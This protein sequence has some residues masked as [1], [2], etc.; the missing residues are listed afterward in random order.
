M[1][2]VL[3]VSR[4]GYYEWLNRGESLRRKKERELVETIRAIFTECKGRYGSPRILDELRARGIRCGKSRIERIM[5]DLGLR[6]RS[7]RC[8]RVTTDSKHSYP[9]APNVLGQEFNAQAPNQVW[10]ADITYIRTFEGW[11]YL[12]A[13]IDLFSRRIV[14]WAMSETI[15]ADLTMTALDMAIQCRRPS[16]GLIHHSDRGVHYACHAYQKVLQQADM[17][18]SMSRKGNCWDNAPMESFFS[19]LKTE[20]VDGKTY[21]SRSHA[22]RDIFEFIEI[23]YNRKRRHSSIG[24]MSPSN[25]ES[26]RKC[27]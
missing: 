10:L 25:F 13:V 7:K 4:S 17:V 24:S 11:L 22:K 26:L 3:N 2:R 1:C 14:G 6:A 19:T 16:K 15:T 21:L 27:A 20:C 9:I 8:F 18:C 5:R 12:A 23:D